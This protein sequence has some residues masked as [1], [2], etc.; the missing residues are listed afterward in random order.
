MNSDD[1]SALRNYL[2][3]PRKLVITTHRSP[4][5]D[6]IGSSLGLYL[7]LHKMGHEVAVIVPDEFPAFLA[8]MSGAESVLVYESAPSKA[9]PVLRA[10]EMIFCLDYNAYHRTGELG[11][12]L[13]RAN[14]PKVLIDH[15]QSP[16]DFAAYLLS[17]TSASSTAQL[18]YEFMEGM[19][20]LQ[21]LDREIAECL[22]SG[23][24]TDTGSFRFNST[25]ERTHYIA[26]QLMKTGMENHLVHQRLFDN[27]S[28]NRLRLLGFCLSEKLVVL[29]EYRTAYIALT[30]SEL[31]RFNYKKGDTEGIVNYALSLQNIV[32]AA[33]ITERE[34]EIR[35]SFRSKDGWDVNR[36]AR[37][38]F[39]GGGHIH[40]AGGAAQI[41]LAAT[42]EKLEGHL[43]EHQSEL[44]NA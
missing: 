7:A 30:K 3:E 28:I 41:S 5:G 42:L 4:D 2:S 32:F 18:I 10:A 24:V 33:F 29:P 9:L 40:A 6:A 20:M 16:D 17:D 15:H 43:A 39:N 23:L 21:L 34:R 8:W 13:E 11:L 27:N 35:L 12:H 36:F 25:S 19:E 37:A 38:Y 1:F 22:Y 14:V 31:K 44:Q 26:A